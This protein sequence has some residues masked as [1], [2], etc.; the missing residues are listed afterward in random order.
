[1]KAFNLL[2]A[3]I[4]SS[5]FT[6][7]YSKTAYCQLNVIP[8]SPVTGTVVFIQDGEGNPTWIVANM[9]GMTP[10]YHG[11]HIHESSN[12]TDGCTS[13]GSH[14]NPFNMSHGGPTSNVRHVGDLGNVLADLT[15]NARLN[16]DDNLITLEGETSIVGRAC[17]V[18]DMYDDYGRGGQND[19]MTT[20]HAGGRINCG[21][22]IE[23]V[24]F[25]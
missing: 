7:S 10:G 25:E 4:A 9:D 19:S 24:P 21:E 11:F 5:I 22:V 14:Y 6:L 3:L 16:M 18:H 8:D 15:G 1:M 20:G 2:F 12:F 17:V 23:G 13:A